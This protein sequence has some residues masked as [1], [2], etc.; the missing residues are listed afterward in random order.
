MRTYS[1][2]A[3]F[4]NLSFSLLLL[5]GAACSRAD[6]PIA[7]PLINYAQFQNIVHTASA[8]REVHRMSEKEF[9][10]ALH[11][12]DTIVLDARSPA[13]YRL[14]HV[15]GAVN[16]PFTDFTAASLARVIPGRDTKV[17]IYCNNNFTGSPTAFAAKAPA[18]SLNL[19]TYTSLIAYGYANVYE[20][21]PLLDVRSTRIPFEGSEVSHF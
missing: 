3:C 8:A 4:T 21:G 10:T 9:L 2:A 19:S 7:N 11:E 17:V 5:S 20:L 13:M 1:V 12:P 6:E 16:L 18:A 15:R 14:R